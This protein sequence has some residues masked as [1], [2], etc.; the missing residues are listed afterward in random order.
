MEVMSGVSELSR[1]S[2]LLIS[3]SGGCD[4]VALT[5][6]LLESGYKRL[7]LCYF[8]HGYRS[9]AS[10]QRDIAFVTSFATSLSLPY[11][12]KKC[13]VKF[14][15]TTYGC[16]VEEAGHVLRR[17]LLKHMA[18]LKQVDAVLTAHHQND[19]EETMVFRLVKGMHS[20][21]T[22]LKF[23][24]PFHD[25]CFLLRPL[26]TFQKSQLQS[27]LDSIDQSFVEDETNHSLDY[28]RNR[29][30]Q[31]LIPEFKTLNAQFSQGMYRFFDTH[32]QLM[33]DHLTDIKGQEISIQW[34]MD[35]F[36]MELD[37]MGSM[38]SIQRHYVMMT[39]LQQLL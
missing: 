22:P 29:I 38:T 1:S 34:S 4:S 33:H 18:S 6:L 15:S 10:R 8:D 24:M 5:R 2:Q 14:V 32:D 30:R 21:G 9:D 17:A 37:Q 19:L 31:R 35:G 13:P 25:Q 3:F 16:S 39:V 11:S 12:I 20:T 36:R 26:L 7:H 23:R 27:F 28:E